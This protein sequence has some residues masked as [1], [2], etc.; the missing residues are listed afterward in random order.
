MKCVVTVNL[1][2]VRSRNT[3]PRLKVRG[4]LLSQKKQDHTIPWYQK[5]MLE[6]EM[7]KCYC[8]IL[9]HKFDEH[10]LE[11]TRLVWCLF[12]PSG[13]TIDPWVISFLV[14]EEID[15]GNLLARDSFL[16][17]KW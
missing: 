15:C 5:S 4:W 8:V 2:P 3:Q 13:G 9:S 11:D 12:Y 6:F 10:C 1:I 14:V 7:T 17:P 16:G